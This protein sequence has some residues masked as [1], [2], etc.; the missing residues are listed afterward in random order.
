MVF[1]EFFGLN[2]ALVLN[3]V[4]KKTKT[5]PCHNICKIF[6]KAKNNEFLMHF[7]SC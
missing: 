2:K 5:Y 6:K 4:L 1:P 3:F 7:H